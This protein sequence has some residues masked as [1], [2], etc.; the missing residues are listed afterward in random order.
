MEHPIITLFKPI[1]ATG[2]S[3]EAMGYM[4]QHPVLLS[5]YYTDLLRKFVGTLAESDQSRVLPVM[6]ARAAAFADLRAG[7]MKIPI[8][9]QILEL[10]LKAFEGKYTIEY[11]LTV[12]A[13]PEFFAELLYPVV[14][15]TCET[16]EQGVRQNWRPAV[17]I[18]RILM[19]A[20]DARG[21][22]VTENQQAMELTTV[23]TWLTVACVTCSDVPDGRIFRDA[24]ARG[25]ALAD[26]DDGGDPPAN[27]L[28]R[29]GVLHL[30]PY[31]AGRSSKNLDQQLRDWHT[32]LFEEYGDK[33]AGVT[34]EELDM[35]R[36]EEALPK[37]VQYLRRAAARRSGEARGKTLKAMAQALLWHDVARIPFDRAESVAVARESLSLLPPDRFRAEHAEL[38]YIV[39]RFQ[40]GGSDSSAPLIARA[41]ELLVVP[42]E[43]WIRREGE[44]STLNIFTANAGAISEENPAL[45][46]KLLMAIDDL[47][48]SQPEA[49][50]R[51]HDEALLQ[52]VVRSHKRFTPRLDGTPLGP[53]LQALFESARREGWPAQKA[54]YVLLSLA[55]S[56]TTT[57]Q[58]GEGLEALEFCSDIV[59]RSGSDAVLDRMIPFLRA[60]LQTGAAVNAYN[61]GDIGQAASLY[62][63]GLGGEP[64]CQP[65]ARRTRHPAPP[66]RPCCARKAAGRR[67]T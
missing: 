43:E 55:A 7:K 3:D 36:I 2:G 10:A 15:A 42:I 23:E 13:K 4:R 48:R 8:T 21:K 12:A 60:V 64:G 18:L 49:R 24:V 54:A 65:A 9:S 40:Q 5:P 62:A 29:L 14:T 32:R 61:A 16:A 39:E 53:K 25:D 11:A 20:L 27:I 51:V 58:E 50:R 59:K 47:E 38:N 44:S 45:A 67:R 1:L 28:H 56:T 41:Q 46:I 26:L 22:V 52:L 37:A 17:G 66:S 35:P 63:N 6:N 34:N 19:G 31:V 33:L 30:D 57:D